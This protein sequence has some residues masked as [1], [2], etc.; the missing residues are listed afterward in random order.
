MAYLAGRIPI[1]HCVSEV[2]T[3]PQDDASALD[4]ETMKRWNMI[5][6]VF[7]SDYLGLEPNVK[8]RTVSRSAGE[9]V[10]DFLSLEH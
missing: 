2:L 9:L 3:F 6:R 4:L 8:S 7:I 10:S 5:L 1:V